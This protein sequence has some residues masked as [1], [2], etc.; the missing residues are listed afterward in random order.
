MINL[1][2]RI[3][4]TTWYLLVLSITFLV[5]FA[6]IY[7]G[8]RTSIHRAVDGELAARLEGVHTFLWRHLPWQSGEELL[9]EFQEHSGLRAG[10]DLYQVMNSTGVW[11]YQPAAMRQLHIPSEPP[12][13]TRPPHYETLDRQGQRVRVLSGTVEV[14]GKLYAVQVATLVTAFYVVLDRFSWIAVAASPFL[15]LLSGLGGYWLSKRAMA[16]VDEIAQTARSISEQNLSKRLIVPKPK[17]ELRRLVETLNEMLSRL[18]S[19]FKRMTQFTADASHELRTPIAIIRTTAEYLQQKQR[20]VSEYEEA[21]AQILAEAELTSELIEKLMTLARADSQAVEL[22]FSS[23]DLCNVVSEVIASVTALTESKQLSLS[24]SAP[25]HPVF[26]WADRH[27]IRRLLLIL[28]D[29]AIKYTG[30]GGRIVVSVAVSSEG[31]QLEVRDSGIG[32]SSSDLQHVFERFYRADKIR[33]R[34]SGGAGLGLAIA[35]WIADVHRARIEV[36]SALEKGSA[37]CVV[38]ATDTIHADD[39]GLIGHMTPAAKG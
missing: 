28:I 38:F 36:H 6:G 30:P 3:R 29:N 27:A 24:V 5:F 20:S 2:V 11:V 16:P 22:S 23:L 13:R 14:A 10:G 34:E 19:A 35:K 33:S 9:L 15:V 39:E 17:D 25:E 1:P 26:I 21:T 32:I 8:M 12:N 7:F 4:L 37:F 18:E 31:V